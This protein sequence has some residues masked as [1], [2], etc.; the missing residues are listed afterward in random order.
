MSEGPETVKKFIQH[1]SRAHNASK[2]IMLTGT[3][4][5]YP[6][7]REERYTVS[8]SSGESD[9]VV[10]G[11]PSDVHRQTKPLCLVAIF[12]SECHIDS[13][14]THVQLYNPM[15]LLRLMSRCL[16]ACRAWYIDLA[17]Y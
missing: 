8:R 5:T 14:D 3:H 15:R 6:T 11:G 10:P 17:S 16:P 4:D 13:I 12:V 2:R 7:R 9:P 1:V